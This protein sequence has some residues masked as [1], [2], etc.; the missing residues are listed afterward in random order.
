MNT[1]ARRNAGASGDGDGDSA[2]PRTAGRRRRGRAA[3][4]VAA[5]LSGSEIAL[6][7]P[8]AATVGAHSKPM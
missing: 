1:G 2:A 3:A 6:A 7:G 5:L 4:C 8:A